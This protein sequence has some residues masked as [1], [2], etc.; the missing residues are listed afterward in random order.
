MWIEDEWDE[1]TLVSELTPLQ[2]EVAELIVATLQLEVRPEE[3]APRG[4]LFGGD[5]LGLDSIDALELVL[6]I[7][8]RYGFE[9][10]ADDENNVRIF[11]SLASLC[12]HIAALRT[13]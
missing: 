4:G 10:R 12:D 2:R 11:A 9:F 5:G 1:E 13:K 3:I 8:E 6:E 7:S